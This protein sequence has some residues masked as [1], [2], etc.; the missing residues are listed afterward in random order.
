MAGN[1]ASA[2]RA[3]AKSRPASKRKGVKLGGRTSVKVGTKNGKPLVSN[4]LKS[5]AIYFGFDDGIITEKDKYGTPRVIRGSQSGANSIKVPLEDNEGLKAGGATGSKGSGKDDGVAFTSIPMPPGMTIPQIA[6]FL[7]TASKHKPD[8][9]VTPNGR[10]Y[11][12]VSGGA[13]KGK[14]TTK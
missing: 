10:T 7:A 12:V 13:G 1:A 5:V 11:P 4:M 9:F 2:A 3:G 8:R 14:P 6:A